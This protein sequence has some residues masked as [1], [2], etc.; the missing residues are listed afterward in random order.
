M[1]T[2]RSRTSAS[3]YDG[4]QT[5]VEVVVEGVVA[6]REAFGVLDRETFAIGVGLVRRPLG[7]V[8][9]VGLGHHLGCADGL[10]PRETDRAAVDLGDAHA[11]EFA[12][13][14]GHDAL[15]VDGV[16]E[17]AG[18]H[19]H[20]GPERPHAHF[21]VGGAVG[22]FDTR[23]QRFL[24]HFSGSVTQVSSASRLQGLLHAI[25]RISSSVRPAS[26]SASA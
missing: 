21:G 4:A 13:A 5:R 15:L 24:G 1:H 19:A 6:E 26:N 7:D 2:V 14:H 23:H 16:A 11:G 12:F 18:R 17:R 22:D 10:A 8:R 9:V 25:V 3:L 20:L